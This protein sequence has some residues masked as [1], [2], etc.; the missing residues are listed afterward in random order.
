M[1]NLNEG[2][3]SLA[4]L[5]LI[6]SSLNIPKEEIDFIVSY[7]DK[8]SKI[9]DGGCGAGRHLMPLADMNFEVDGVEISKPLVDYIN[10]R[11]SDKNYKNNPEIITSDLRRFSAARRYDI[12]LLLNGTAN[13][14]D[15]NNLKNVVI[16]LGNNLKSNG[17]MIVEFGMREL[18]ERYLLEQQHNWQI[19]LTDTKFLQAH[20]EYHSSLLEGNE[21]EGK[22][23]YTLF[24]SNKL[25]KEEIFFFRN[26]FFDI[27]RLR[28]LFLSLGLELLHCFQDY[29]KVDFS[30]G[31]E[32]CIIVARFNT[33]NF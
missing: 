7:C 6:K 2:W 20:I 25:L 27:E 15:F 22:R 10:S 12:I 19:M 32:S 23:K 16:N 3:N 14:F 18:Y 5:F 11:I 1:K 13:L 33:T 8:N 31:D 24:A 21:I 9:L 28:V 17:L 29:S 26:H 30:L 4:G